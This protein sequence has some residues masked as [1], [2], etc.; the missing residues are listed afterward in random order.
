[1][2]VTAEQ[3]AEKRPLLGAHRF[4]VVFTNGCFD[5]LHPDHVAHLQAVRAQGGKRA[6][7]VVGLNSDKSVR[8][9]KGPSRPLI[10]QEDR[11]AMLDG[12]RAVDYVIYF[13]GKRC[14]DLIAQVRP[15]VYCKAGDYTLDTLDPSERAAL[16]ECGAEIRFLPL[17]G[18]YSTTALVEK[19]KGGR[20]RDA[21]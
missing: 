4:V 5:L 14:A 9:L 16:E 2:I 17:L 7:L 3:F 11:A 21:E 12:L 18:N 6:V 19:L 13:D 1:M 15:D 20:K 8:A 10:P